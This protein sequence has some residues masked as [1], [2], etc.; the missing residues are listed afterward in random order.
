MYKWENAVL[1]MKGMALLAKLTSG[2]TLSLIRAVTGTGYVLPDIL[3]FQTGVTDEKQELSFAAQ[4]YPEDGMCAVPV[5]LFNTGLPS[6]Y[7]AKQIGIYA[8]DPDDG[9]ILFL[10]AQA[11]DG[12]GTDIPSETEMPGYSAEWTFYLMYGQADGVTVN[13]DPSNMVN[14]EMVRS[15][16]REHSSDTNNPHGVTKEQLGLDNVDNTADTDKYVA[17]AQRAGVADKAKY[18]LTVR[19][20]GGRTEGVNM[21]T[22]DGST[23]KAVNVTAAK[24]CAEPAI[25]STDSPGCYYRT[26]SGSADYEWINPPMHPNVEYRTTERWNGRVVYTQMFK[27]ATI[28]ESIT[29]TTMAN[30]TGGYPIRFEAV[31]MSSDTSIVA[32]DI[33]YIVEGG[34]KIR[35]SVSVDKNYI[36]GCWSSGL[37]ALYTAN[38]LSIYVRVWYV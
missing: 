8:M 9:E 3:K 17:Y 18:A 1:T 2:H 19:L 20:D 13:V 25:E 5:R 27:L 11:A 33:D 26:V 22:F 15:I 28:G 31:A 12:E 23:S 24:I 34:P 35:L 32:P 21:W 16:L 4:S 6:G 14:E 10:I 30:P 29:Y 7:T 36:K 38:P 37:N